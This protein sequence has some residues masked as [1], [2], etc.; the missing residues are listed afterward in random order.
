MNYQNVVL[1]IIAACLIVITLSITGIIK[2]VKVSVVETN[3]NIPVSLQQVGKE[4]NTRF[5]LQSVP[6][7]IVE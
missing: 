7:T 6:V 4:R 1:T 2:P 5:G 3:G